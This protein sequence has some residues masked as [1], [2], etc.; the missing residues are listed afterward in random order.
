MSKPAEVP[1]VSYLIENPIIANVYHNEGI[2]S[3]INNE[4]YPVTIPLK[5]SGLSFS[6]LL[7][8]NLRL[9]AT[10]S[11]DGACVPFGAFTAAI[12]YVVFS[13]DLEIQNIRR[14]RNIVNLASTSTK[15]GWVYVIIPIDEL[16]TIPE[17]CYDNLFVNVYLDICTCSYPFC[18]KLDPV[19]ENKGMTYVLDFKIIGDTC[20]IPPEP[21]CCV[22]KPSPVTNLAKQLAAKGGINARA[23]C[24]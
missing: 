6:G 14:E 12:R 2:V 23:E 16:V 24:E 8:V 15:D 1:N 10:P 17:G 9:P 20:D 11:S 7:G 22:L 4:K 18:Q 21:E 19:A 13:G 5:G 3:Q